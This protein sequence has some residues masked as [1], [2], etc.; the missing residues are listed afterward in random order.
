MQTADH[1]IAESPDRP[2]TRLAPSPTGA[3]HLGNA[4]TFL[5]NWAMAVRRGWRVVMRVEDLDTPRVKAGA[6]ASALRDL[7]WLGLTWDGMD[8]P[9]QGVT[10]QRD[11]LSPYR[12]ALLRLHERGLIYPCSLTRR[13]VAEAS[14]S[15]PQ[16]TFGPGVIDRSKHEQ[17]YPGTSRDADASDTGDL[18]EPSDRCWRV[19]V[20]DGARVVR[21]GFMG[22]VSVD[23]QAE[24]GDFIVAS[25]AGLPA[26]QLAVVVDDR[27]QGVTEVVRG[28]DLIGSAARQGWLWAM[29]GHEGEPNWW[30]L[31]LVLGEDGHRLAKRHGDTR[32]GWF[33][34]RGVSAER[35]VG[36]LAWWSGVVEEPMAMSAAEFAGAFTLDALP[37][38]PAVMDDRAWRWLGVSPEEAKP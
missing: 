13:E 15:A 28:D 2:V 12:D 10:R 19:R 29:L 34:E 11:E 3:L 27:R 33:A 17:R 7:R 31:P 23:V 14:A 26:Y 18:L 25:K 5:I 38:E 30:H 16:A 9:G 20:P 22:E 32:V 4:R 35:V 36:L 37:R 6:E 21:D 1:S 8:R 24:V